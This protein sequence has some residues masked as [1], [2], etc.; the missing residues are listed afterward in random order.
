MHFQTIFKD[1]DYKKIFFN[2][3]KTLC[4]VVFAYYLLTRFTGCPFRFFF[5]ISCPGCGMTRALLAA[6]HLDFAAALS[7]HPL[8]F[9]LPLFL[10]GYYLDPWI[11]WSRHTFLF[12]F[13]IVLFVGVYLI[14][15]LVLHDPVVAWH[16]S[17]G[18][19]LSP[20]FS[21]LQH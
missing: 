13:G 3:T 1:S 2:K 20:F 11:D 5:G 6:L 4:V 21:L 19:L 9:L 18:V 15:L 14:R 16:P 10:L 8:F 7:F 17:S 12:I